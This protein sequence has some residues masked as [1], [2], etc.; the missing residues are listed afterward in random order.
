MDS[1][2]TVM[3]SVFNQLRIK[4]MNTK[5]EQL[6]VFVTNVDTMKKFIWIFILLTSSTLFAQ[7]KDELYYKS[8]TSLNVLILSNLRKLVEIGK[9]DTLCMESCIFIKFNASKKS[10]ITN[11]QISGDAPEFLISGLKS[12]LIKTQ[13]QWQNVNEQTFILPVVY[14]FEANCKPINKSTTAVINILYNFQDSKPEVYFPGD[15]KFVPIKCLLLNP[16]FIKSHF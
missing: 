15:D 11:I 4:E 3:E 2:K 10:G 8:D 16:L 9:Y 6:E 1:L 12:S 13:S 5:T 7:N 14:I